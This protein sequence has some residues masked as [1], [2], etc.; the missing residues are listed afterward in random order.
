MVVKR[1]KRSNICEYHFHPENARLGISN[2]H[3]VHEQ[4][5]QQF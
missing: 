5:G 4:P 2:G 3:I 1:A